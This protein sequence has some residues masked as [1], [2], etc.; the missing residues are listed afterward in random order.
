MNV[1]I[2]TPNL[3]AKLHDSYIKLLY[4]NVIGKSIADQVQSTGSKSSWRFFPSMANFWRIFEIF[5][6]RESDSK[7]RLA[8]LSSR[9]LFSATSSRLCFR[10]AIALFDIVN[11]NFLL[12]K[13]TSNK[14]YT[15]LL[16]V[17]NKIKNHHRVNKKRPHVSQAW[18]NLNKN[19]KW[20]RKILPTS[21]NLLL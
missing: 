8:E 20:R 13:T 6:R 10:N 1:D 4:L 18:E 12:T 5:S 19:L 3:F 16:S 14:F 2:G 17:L 9:L 15:I 11:L 21:L 7:F